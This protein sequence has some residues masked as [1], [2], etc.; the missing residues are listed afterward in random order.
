MAFL[1]RPKQTHSMPQGAEIFTRKGEM[2]A[3][4]RDAK[5]LCNN[6]TALSASFLTHAS[7]VT[8]SKLRS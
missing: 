4:W 7:T 3:R 8:Y 2:L 5:G 6:N 1:Y